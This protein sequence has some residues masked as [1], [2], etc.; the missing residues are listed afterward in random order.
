MGHELLARIRYHQILL[1]NELYTVP[2]D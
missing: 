2:S 1:E